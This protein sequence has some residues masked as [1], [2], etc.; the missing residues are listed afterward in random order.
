MTK[1]AQGDRTGCLAFTFASEAKVWVSSVSAET[2]SY[3]TWT[4]PTE[5][6]V[7]SDLTKYKTGYYQAQIPLF[8]LRKTAFMLNLYYTEQL[9]WSHCI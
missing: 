8:C 1:A 6:I 9:W 5:K 2:H 3:G 7:L 4:S